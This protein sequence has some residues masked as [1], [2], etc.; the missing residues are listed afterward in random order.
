METR[1]FLPAIPEGIEPVVRIKHQQ[2]G[3]FHFEDG[4]K[5]QYEI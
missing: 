5:G 4:V 2:Q 1:R 3:I